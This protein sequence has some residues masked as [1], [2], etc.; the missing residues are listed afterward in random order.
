MAKKTD[1][2]TYSSYT[3]AL[4]PSSQRRLTKT[5]K[6][7]AKQVERL[8]KEEYVRY[9]AGE[10]VSGHLQDLHDYQA[11]L[12]VASARNH[13]HTLS[14]IRT[15]LWQNQATGFLLGSYHQTGRL[16]GE[17][18]ATYHRASMRGIERAFEYDDRGWLAKLTGRD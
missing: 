1:I 13:E 15:E 18:K 6:Q 2:A 4:A 3:G 5:D 12:M 16:H 10:A 9:R 8:A 14:T 7:L 11:E 17:T